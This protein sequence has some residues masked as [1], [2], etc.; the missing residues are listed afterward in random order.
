MWQSSQEVELALNPTKNLLRGHKD[1][2]ITES[3][4]FN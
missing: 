4:W 1:F 2:E 3:D